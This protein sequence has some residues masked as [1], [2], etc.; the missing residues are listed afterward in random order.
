MQVDA[1]QW[2]FGS[3]N[4]RFAAPWQD[5]KNQTVLRTLESLVPSRVASGVSEHSLRRTVTSSVK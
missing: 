1:S 5:W 2:R 4:I 3:E